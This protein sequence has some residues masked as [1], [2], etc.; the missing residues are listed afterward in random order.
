MYPINMNT[1]LQYLEFPYW[2]SGLGHSLCSMAAAI[3][4]ASTLNLV[5]VLD[6][7]HRNPDP[8][9]QK[10]LGLRD[11]TVES[12][13]GEACGLGHVG[14]Y[15]RCL[16]VRKIDVKCAG[17]N[18]PEPVAASFIDEWRK[19][20]ATEGGVVL[21]QKERSCHFC[22]HSNPAIAHF[23]RD[24]IA[25]VFDRDRSR[26]CGGGDHHPDA[27]T[28]GIHLRRGDVPQGR[29]IPWTAYQAVLDELARAA[30]PRWSGVAAC[31]IFERGQAAAIK[32]EVAAFEVPNNVTLYLNTETQPIGRRLHAKN[33]NE[34]NDFLSLGRD[35]DVFVDSHSSY[36]YWASLLSTGVKLM[37]TEAMPWSH[38]SCTVKVDPHAPQVLNSQHLAQALDLYAQDKCA[39]LGPESSNTSWHHP[40]PH[41]WTPHATTT[42]HPHGKCSQTRS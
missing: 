32:K 37:I 31:V 13:C 21:K 25:S 41:P 9:V 12:R 27:L 14:E 24:R 5:L 26:F 40:Q 7:K 15:P 17:H 6:A 2:T 36:A 8:S 34:V 30:A 33:D 1:S 20:L 18:N 22:S 19:R 29:R 23:V 4:V 35:F 16:P 11:P 39:G 3:Y 10:L 28:V 38:L 42:N